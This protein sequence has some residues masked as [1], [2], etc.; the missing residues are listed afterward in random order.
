MGFTML[1]TLR[2]TLLLSL[3]AVGLAS[4]VVAAPASAAVPSKTIIVA[5]ERQ[6]QRGR[7]SR[8]PHLP[9]CRRPSSAFLQAEPS[10]SGVVAT[11][12]RSI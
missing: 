7:D 1:L 6:R 5:A 3:A 12:R 8:L 11:T 2:P 4:L 9:R 10:T